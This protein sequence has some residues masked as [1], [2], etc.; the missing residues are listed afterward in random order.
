MGTAVATLR[1]MPESPDT[2]LKHI[3]SEAIKMISEF[4]DER[5]KKV[6]ILPVAF[7]LNSV[8]ITFLMDEKKG[9]TE[10][11]EKKIS[12]IEG[13]QSVELSDIR[14]IIG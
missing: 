3:E 5:Q 8:N 7:G 14:R 1:I 12:T 10:A 9:D 6:E 4:S 2:N 11:L 13:V